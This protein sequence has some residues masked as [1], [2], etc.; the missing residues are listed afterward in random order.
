MAASPV[1]PPPSANSLERYQKLSKV[2]EGNYGVVYKA[3]DVVSGEIVAMKKIRLE[4]EDEGVPGTAIREISLL[5]ELSH[6]NIVDLKEV[7]LSDG[8]LYLVLEFLTD[9][10]TKL[11]KSGKNFSPMV[12][13]NFLFQLLSGITFCHRRRVLHRDL[14]PQNLLINQDGTLKL[15][16]FGLARA[17]GVPIRT[18]THEVVTLW[19]RAPEILLGAT[20][21]AT[22]VD[23]WPI[24]CIFAEMVMLS[25][26]F[27]GD[28]EIDELFKIF[29]VLGT[30]T[31]ESW[32]GVSSLRDFKSTFPKWP[33][34]PLSNV[35][36][37]LDPLGID[38]LT[39]M[40]QYDPR[41]RISAVE[42]MQHPYFDDYKALK[43]KLN[44]KR[45]NQEL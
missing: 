35:V 43:A 16:D 39:Q 37:D 29:R 18:Y 20:Q 42:A 2:G 10:L 33:P 14:K 17:F 3:R 12:I 5:R 27:P 30:P 44:N 32:S 15:A 45:R 7:I 36:K 25:P 1:S 21:Y 28:S 34:Q 22:A 26:L 11:I 38:L 23:I 6:P 9:D 4:R 24:G 41:R 8:R 40:L 13:K 19:Y 31:E